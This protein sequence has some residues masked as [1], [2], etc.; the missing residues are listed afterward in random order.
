MLSTKEYLRVAIRVTLSIAVPVSAMLAILLALTDG[1]KA[2]GSL[3][4]DAVDGLL[5]LVLIPIIS[6]F[7]CVLVSPV[8]RLFYVFL[9]RKNR[10]SKASNPSNGEIKG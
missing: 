8:G 6:V 3:E 1:F 5:F 2:E 9:D 10:K 4:F 7:L